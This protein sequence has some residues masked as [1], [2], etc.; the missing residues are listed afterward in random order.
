[1]RDSTTLDVETFFEV[2]DI[3][4]ALTLTPSTINKRL[5]RGTLKPDAVTVRGTN[6][7]RR[8]TRDRLVEERKAGGR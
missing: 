4:A 1:M 2:H 8:A 3:A 5:K 6:L 7:F